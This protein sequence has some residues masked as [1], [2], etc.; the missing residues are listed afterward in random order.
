[1][2]NTLREIMN[3]IDSLWSKSAE[4]TGEDP[5][6]MPG[7]ENDRPA[8]EGATKDDPKVK[9]DTIDNEKNRNLNGAESGSDAPVTKDLA[10]GSEEPVLNADKKPLDSTDVNAK[11]ASA[12]GNSIVERILKA[13]QAKEP[14]AVAEKKA[15]KEA[16]S[17]P[18]AQQQKK[19]AQTGVTIPLDM[20]MMA[21]IAAITLA[22]DEGQQAVQAA[23]AKRAGAEFAAEV[24]DTLEKRAAEEQA[25]FE[26][27]KGA[28][29]AEDMIG[30]LQEAQGAAD[31]E[32]ALG[33]MAPGG[34]APA[35]PEAP[36]GEAP[37]VMDPQQAA[38]ALSEFSDEEIIEACKELEDEG[39]LQPGTTDALVGAA[40]G[41][42][43]SPTA[44]DSDAALEDALTEAIAN[45]EI[46]EE[47]LQ[48]VISSVEGGEPSGDTQAEQPAEQPA[49]EKAASANVKKDPADVMRKIAG[50]LKKADARVKARKIITQLGRR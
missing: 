8:P 36:G 49:E 24:F 39:V 12:L 1:M 40:A 7:S 38:E 28:Q 35:A 5:N 21:K 47:D 42:G 27:M 23:L 33:M 32:S 2:T 9:D 30:D 37:A 20:A 29:A 50:V 15:E 17:Q 46:S 34:E 14:E 31:A 43:G 22:D 13:K 45:G 25:R 16:E 26:F 10:Y 18:K 6:S 41:E 44:I 3:E 48:S 19:E 4:I 11:E